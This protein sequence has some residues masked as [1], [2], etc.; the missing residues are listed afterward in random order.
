MD[1]YELV[2]PY[3]DEPHRFYH[4]IDHIDYMIFAGRKLMNREQY[5]AVLFHDIVYDAKRK[6]NEEQSASLMYKML[7][8]GYDTMKECSGEAVDTI[9]NIILDTRTH[10]ATRPESELVLDLDLL[11]MSDSYE[12]FRKNSD[13]IRKEYSHLSDN[14]W[15]I[16]RRYFFTELLNR[17]KILTTN[18]F[19][20]FDKDIR[21]NIKR[22][23]R[24]L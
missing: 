8:A 6:D 3:Y 24:E 10:K 19:S 4:T 14:E 12:T 2:K 5:M 11:G 21:N 16:G 15:S 22:E 23:L 20:M 18:K 9:A 13:N 7:D 1:Y 17:P